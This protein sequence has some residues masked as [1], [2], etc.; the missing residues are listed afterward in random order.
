MLKK[1]WSAVG[2]R[3]WIDD[4]KPA[5]LFA[6]S[7]RVKAPANQPTFD[8]PKF[9][10]SKISS[11]P[12]YKRDTRRNYPR[13]AVYSQADVAQIISLQVSPKIAQP[14]VSASNSENAVS[15]QQSSQ[16]ATTKSLNEII[17]TLNSPIYSQTNLP[18]TPG[19]P[20]VYNFS[21][22]QDEQEPGQYYPMY[23]VY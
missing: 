6:D 23:K 13:L 21:N 11:N 9:E 7:F 12:Y 18:P 14:E 22:E 17:S 15:E 5:N 16:V 3:V 2:K 10:A 8:M 4:Y 20:Y 1:F 19:T